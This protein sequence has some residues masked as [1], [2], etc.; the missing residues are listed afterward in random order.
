MSEV[1][2]CVRA[3]PLRKQYAALTE[4]FIK[5]H[6]MECITVDDDLLFPVTYDVVFVGDDQFLIFMTEQGQYYVRPT[7]N[8]PARTQ[9][10]DGICRYGGYFDSFQEA[11]DTAVSWLSL[12]AEKLPMCIPPTRVFD[13]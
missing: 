5:K 6:N 12:A 10:R 1:T 8:D 9:P 3:E 13:N 2:L 7:N 11:L 4:D